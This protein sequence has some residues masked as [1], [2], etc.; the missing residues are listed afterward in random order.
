MIS[1]DVA[2]C[3]IH[4]H[5]DL[6][7]EANEIANLLWT[8]KHEVSSRS[9]ARIIKR[10]D[11]C[12]TVRAP[13]AHCAHAARSDR[14]RTASKP[15]ARGRARPHTRT[16]RQRANARAQARA[17]AHRTCGREPRARRVFF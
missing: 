8:P 2:W 12:G 11:E 16:A 4:M 3:I 10:F 5:F 9:V 15:R 1:T 14:V 17:R 7:M 13:R 6:D